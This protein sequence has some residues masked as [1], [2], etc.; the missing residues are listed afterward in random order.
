MTKLN[1]G[2]RAP[3]FT[4]L[5]ADNSEIK[6]SDIETKYLVLYF[7]PKDNTPGCT[8]EANDFNDLKDEFSSL[9]ASIVGVS[10]DSIKSH[11]KFREK[12]SLSFDLIS[13]PDGIICDKYGVWV[14]KSMFGKKYMGIKRATFLISNGGEIIHIWPSVSV[15]GHA[16]EVLSFIKEL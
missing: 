15:K 12:Y 16:S 10:R 7:Y 13:D 4:G 6:L 2:D 8:V 14:E 1:S 9:S 3:D 11:C 5:I